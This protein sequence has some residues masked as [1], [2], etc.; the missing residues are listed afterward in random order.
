MPLWWLYNIFFCTSLKKDAYLQIEEIW[1]LSK[2][3]KNKSIL[4]GIIVKLQNTEDKEKN[5]K[6]NQRENTIYLQWKNKQTD[7]IFPIGN[8]RSLK[9]TGHYLQNAVRGGKNHQARTLYY[10]PSGCVLHPQLT[11]TTFFR[12]R[13]SSVTEGL[14]RCL[15]LGTS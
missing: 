4:S 3:N 8:Y 6:S 7:N 15:K 2:I 1:V 11:F 12:N 5:F 13:Y 10:S 14:G 9:M